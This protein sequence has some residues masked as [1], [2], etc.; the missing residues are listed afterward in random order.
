MSNQGL[1][2]EELQMVAQHGSG[3]LERS[4]AVVRLARRH[5]RIDEIEEIAEVVN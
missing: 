5:D 3:P 4:L 2:D 1:S